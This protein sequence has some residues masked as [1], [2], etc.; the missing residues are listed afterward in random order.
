M[1]RADATVRLDGVMRSRRI[2]HL[3]IHQIRAFASLLTA[4]G[5]R[6]AGRAF[7]VRVRDQPIVRNI[8]DF[9]LGCRRL[10]P[11]FEAAQACAR[12][13][14]PLGHEHPHAVRSDL[15]LADLTRESDYPVL[16]HLAPIAHEL[17]RVFDL[18]GSVGNLFYC[19]ARHLPFADE[20]NWVVYDLPIKRTEGARL[21][22]ERAERRLHFTDTLDSASGADLFI[23]SGAAHYFVEPLDQM[24]RR[25]T[26]LPQRVIINR[27]ACSRDRPLIT[28]QDGRA[29]FVACKLHPRDA[30]VAGM[31]RLGYALR[32]SWPVH[33]HS[34]W[35]PL[36]PDMSYGHYFGFYFELAVRAQ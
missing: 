2:S 9:L 35:V 32:A 17:R 30:L 18:G 14:A 27:I 21:A 10:F 11:D 4:M 16:F 26:R 34:L 19:Y 6:S 25:L 33:E 28:V 3:R 12:H 31:E 7:L 20:M 24:L 23:V 1:A 8:F 15:E 13:Y 5:N 22:L 29:Y 36:Y